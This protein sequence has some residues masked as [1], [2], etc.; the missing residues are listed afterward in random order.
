MSPLLFNLFLSDLAKQFDST[1]NKVTLGNVG[2]NS[3]FWADDL[4]L[5]SESKEGLDKLLG[6][7]ENYCNF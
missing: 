7:L 6:I 3:I 2:I 5:F 4:V 1:D